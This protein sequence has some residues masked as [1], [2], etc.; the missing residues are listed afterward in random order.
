MMSEQVCK[1]ALRTSLH[2]WSS[3]DSLIYLV[4]PHIM[5]SCHTWFRA[6]PQSSGLH[7]E[8]QAFDLPGPNGADVLHEPMTQWQ[9]PF[10]CG[11]IHQQPRSALG[12][13]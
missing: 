11:H 9:G 4:A 10:I 7:C 12:L 3:R 5:S 1:F 2:S 8:R 6:A 13:S